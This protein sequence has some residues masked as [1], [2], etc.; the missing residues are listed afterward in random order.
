[1]EDGSGLVGV[2]PPLANSDY[3][4]EH[5]TDLACMIRYG[6]KGEIVVNGR[7]YNTE[8]PGSPKLHEF[9][10]T[11]IIN[12]MNTSWGNDIPLVKHLDARAEL[13]ACER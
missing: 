10:I 2:I 12:Y 5:Q 11:N 6:F 4:R 13:E 8:M 7:T 1:M 9:E 3:L